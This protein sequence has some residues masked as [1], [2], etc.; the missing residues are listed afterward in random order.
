MPQRVMRRHRKFSNLRGPQSSNFPSNQTPQ[1]Q[2]KVP[3][4][5]HSHNRILEGPFS[6]LILL[7]YLTDYTPSLKLLRHDHRMKILNELQKKLKNRLQK[8]KGWSAK[9][10]PQNYRAFFKYLHTDGHKHNLLSLSLSLLSCSTHSLFCYN[11]RQTPRCQRFPQLSFP[12][13]SFLLP[14][15]RFSLIF[16]YL[17][18]EP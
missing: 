11:R 2:S 14:S 5:S 10:I 4:F 9:S 1:I 17:L 13:L 3:N 7:S 18:R 12:F 8:T 15:F 16:L 6:M